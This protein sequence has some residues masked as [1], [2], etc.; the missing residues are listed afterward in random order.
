[1]NWQGKWIWAAGQGPQPVNQTIWARKRFELPEIKNARLLIT[2]DSQYRVFI[3]GQWVE[4]GPARAW[5]EH[6]QYDVIEATELLKP[7]ENVIAV[8]A[9]YYGQSNF[10]QVPQEAGLLAQL[11]VETASGQAVGLWH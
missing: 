3:N 8:M 10:H 2:A 9:R 7:G 5:P 1:M 11:E 6:Y 4:D